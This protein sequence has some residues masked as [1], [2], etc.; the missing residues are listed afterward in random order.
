[1]A[2]A[3]QRAYTAIRSG[4]ESGT[5]PS[6]HRLKEGELA[7]EIGVSRTPVREALRRLATD[8][9]VRF[10]PNRG[11]FVAAWSVDD[12]D[13]IFVLRSMLE[14]YAAELAADKITPEEVERLGA[15]ASA[16]EEAAVARS[17]EAH[18]T[19]GALNNEF[20]RLVLGAAHSTRLEETVS[21][22][23]EFPIILETLGRF[24]DED[25][26]RSC[27]QHRELVEALQARDG[28]WAAS[29]MRAHIL[30]AR[31]VYLAGERERREDG[32]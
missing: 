16:I 13:Q 9:L 12:I 19:V 6:G 32:S 25:L 7:D 22:L 11:A 14:S 29:I 24:S 4:I 31:R 1:M 27:A 28:R 5:Y 15:L 23:V 2:T 21:W 17:E 18:R 30:A 3:A 10:V 26:R 20:H 8:Q